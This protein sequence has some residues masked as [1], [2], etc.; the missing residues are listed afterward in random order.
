M[1]SHH[2]SGGP[3]L[4]GYGQQQGLHHRDPQLPPPLGCKTGAQ[5]CL[6]HQVQVRSMAD[7]CSAQPFG[8]AKVQVRGSQPCNKALASAKSLTTWEI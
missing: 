3:R 2:L 6:N 8:S 5:F 4:W 7:G 1:G